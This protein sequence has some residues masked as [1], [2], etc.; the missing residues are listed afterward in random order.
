[1]AL[2]NGK[3]E[4][5]TILHE[6]VFTKTQSLTATI[7]RNK[8]RNFASEQ[9]CISSGAS[10]N[11]A[12][13]ERSGMMALVD[14]AEGAGMIKLESALEGRVIEECLSMFNIDGSIRKSKLLQL[15]SMEPVT[16]IPLG[17]ISVVDMGLIWRLATPTPEDREAKRRD[18]SEYRWI[19]YLDKILVII[20]SRHADAYIIILVNDR[21][22]IPY[23]IKDDERDRR[24]AKYPHIANVFPKP[25]DNFP[26]SCWVQQSDGEF[27]K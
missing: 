21:Y 5:E 7:H 24:A 19:N 16:E 17:Y 3:I 2:Q 22:D 4:A 20:T 11:M 27:H 23:S 6:R 13:M 14:L 15:L 18:G 8:R 10:M 9:I 26:N 12:L 1:M 25:D